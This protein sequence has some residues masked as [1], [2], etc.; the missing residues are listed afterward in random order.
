MIGWLHSKLKGS[1]CRERTIR[2]RTLANSDSR[3]DW[4]VKC[5][6]CR[7]RLDQLLTAMRC[8]I[9]YVSV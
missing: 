5:R 2:S 1:G 3:R 6:S 7:C 9:G 4:G 8:C